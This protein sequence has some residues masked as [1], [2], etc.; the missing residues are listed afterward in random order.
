MERKHG[1]DCLWQMVRDPN[2][3]QLALYLYLASAA[4]G[5]ISV[6]SFVFFFGGG[7]SDIFHFHSHFNGQIKLHD[8]L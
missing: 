2:Q 7:R 1:G 8:E 4:M 5:R 3:Q 6:K